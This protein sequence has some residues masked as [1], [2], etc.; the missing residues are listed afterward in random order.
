MTVGAC[1]CEN[2]QCAKLRQRFVLF[3]SSEKLALCGG[4][5]HFDSRFSEEMGSQHDFIKMNT[6]DFGE[7]EK[8]LSDRKVDFLKVLKTNSFVFILA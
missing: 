4:S 7:I 3:K 8:L 6:T 2:V 1:A 5:L